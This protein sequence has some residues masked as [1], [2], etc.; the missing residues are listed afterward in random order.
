MNKFASVALW[1]ALCIPSIA[2]AWQSCPATGGY[3]GNPPVRITQPG[4]GA[5]PFG[6]TRLAAIPLTGDYRP[7]DLRG[8]SASSSAC[9]AGSA[10]DQP[11]GAHRVYVPG[12]ATTPRAPLVVFLPG[13]NM[14][15]DKHDL[16]LK[17]AAYAG[18]R[19][20]GLS[21]D[22]THNIDAICAPAAVFSSCT[23]DCYASKRDEIILGTDLTPDFDVQ[24]ADSIVE[25]LFTLLAQLYADD[26]GDGTNDHGW[27]A[28]FSPLLAV[29][30]PITVANIRWDQIIIA[31]FSQGAGHA[32]RM[33]KAF[34]LH[35]AFV[36]DGPG[37]MCVNGASELL[38]AP[39]LTGAD[40]SAG[41]PRYGAMHAFWFPAFDLAEG[42]APATWTALGL[43]TNGMA[44]LDEIGTS[45]P[46]PIAGLPEIRIPTGFLPPAQAAY[47]AQTPATHIGSPTG[48]DSECAAIPAPGL[49]PDASQ[50]HGSM[51]D[52]RCMPT[53]QTS[54]ILASSASDAYLFQHYLR[55]F[56]YACDRAVCP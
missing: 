37:D 32:A 19:T 27:D 38:A 2:A 4:F 43:A 36:I 50:K 14:T 7:G 54:G 28:Y 21:Y 35:G 9:S 17:T 56:C 11:C 8:W 16:V 18:Y 31:G 12:P 23:S 22:N 53:T 15:P 46:G 39:W 55:R 49:P 30:V 24:P 25:R 45:R 51:A 42:E 41:R 29:P 26:I 47:T 40:A 3:D 10:A 6:L 52:D 1:I 5:F 20:I 34:L 48:A 44:N 13:S 33:S